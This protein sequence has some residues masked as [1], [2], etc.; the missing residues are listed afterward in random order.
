MNSPLSFLE[1]PMTPPSDWR[2]RCEAIVREEVESGRPIP[3]R[4][5]LVDTSSSTPFPFGEALFHN[6]FSPP[7]HLPT[8][9]VRVYRTS[10]GGFLLGDPEPS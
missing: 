3:E 2:S 6:P 9:M 7:P 5:T 8:W 10:S 4:I 1:R